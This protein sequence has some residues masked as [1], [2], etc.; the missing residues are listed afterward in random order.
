MHRTCLLIK[1]PD[2]LSSVYFA[3][4]TR[5]QVGTCTRRILSIRKFLCPVSASKSIV[6]MPAADT[7]RE[8]V[9]CGGM[10]RVHNYM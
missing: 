4:T 2:L 9:V 3:S 7:T 1:L 8:P 10:S 6:N 5:Y